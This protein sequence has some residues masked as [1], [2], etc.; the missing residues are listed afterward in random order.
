MRRGVFVKAES[1]EDEDGPA[2][3]KI[4]CENMVLAFHL[5]LLEGVSM[6]GLAGEEQYCA[7]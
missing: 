7:W 2:A 5:R 4:R 6:D 3:Q 1:Q